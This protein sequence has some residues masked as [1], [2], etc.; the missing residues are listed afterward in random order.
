L[1]S[2]VAPVRLIDSRI[3]GGSATLGNGRKVIR[4]E[5]VDSLFLAVDA[6]KPEEF[7]RIP[8][9]FLEKARYN[10]RLAR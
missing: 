2:A 9:F 1:F 4:I 10:P 5:D 8:L 3:Y 6:W 7:A